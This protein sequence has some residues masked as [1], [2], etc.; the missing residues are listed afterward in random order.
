MSVYETQTR[1]PT[2]K[3]GK[4]T[5]YWTEDDERAA[6]EGKALRHSFRSLTQQ[7]SKR[8]SLDDKDEK[9]R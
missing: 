8:P 4:Y 5:R 1:T 3:D 2:V 9:T 7:T 6:A